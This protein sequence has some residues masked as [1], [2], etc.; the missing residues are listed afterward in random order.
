MLFKDKSIMLERSST[1]KINML[2][3]SKIILAFA[4]VS[5]YNAQHK[6]AAK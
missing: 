4:V 2:E 5:V 6:V 1:V 3:R